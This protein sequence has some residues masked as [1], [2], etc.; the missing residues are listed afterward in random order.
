MRSVDLQE[1]DAYTIWHGSAT[2]SDHEIVLSTIR[3]L[4]R[5][6]SEEGAGERNACHQPVLQDLASEFASVHDKTSVRVL[7]PGAGLCRL[8]LNIAAAGYMTEGNEISCHQPLASH[9]FLSYKMNASHFQ[10][11]P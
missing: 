6:W 7:V 11:Y 10:L 2:S 3:Q 8:V 1:S 5:D 4:Y 9:F